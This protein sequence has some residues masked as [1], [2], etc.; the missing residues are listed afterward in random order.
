MSMNAIPGTGSTS[1][2]NHLDRGEQKIDFPELR[3]NIAQLVLTR[4]PSLTPP[5]LPPM[6]VITPMNDVPP[7]L[8]PLPG[9][10]VPPPLPPWHPVAGN[11]VLPPPLPPLP[12][13]EVPPPLPPLPPVLARETTNQSSGTSLEGERPFALPHRECKMEDY[14]GRDS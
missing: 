3:V 8:P 9:E 12:C 14:S 11:E 7:P 10:E 6:P 4:L 2:L 5:P 1:A 13:D